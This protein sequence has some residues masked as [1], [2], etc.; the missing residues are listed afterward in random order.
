M[1]LEGFIQSDSELLVHVM[2]NLRGHFTPFLQ[3]RD[4]IYIGKAS[5]EGTVL[6]VIDEVRCSLY[7]L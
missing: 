1:S 2:V 4:Q 6:G 7:L 5:A 3:S